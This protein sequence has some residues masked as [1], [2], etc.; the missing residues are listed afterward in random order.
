MKNTD[1]VLKVNAGQSLTYNVKTDISHPGPLAFYIAKV[2]SGQS[3]ATWEP[4]TAKV[5]T[6][7]YQ[8]HPSISSSG[9]TWPSQGA[10][11]VSVTIPKCLADGEY[12][13]R[14]EHIGL[15]SAS[16]AGGAQ[17]YLSCA[18]LSVSGGSGTWS[19]KNTV[20]FPGAYTATDP[21]IMINIYYPIPTSY[22][23]PGPPAETC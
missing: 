12:L 3:V 16:S 14:V 9:M 20:S 2:P 23:P 13:L 18:Q 6:K 8:D 4:G 5:W 21:G 7:I 22:T 10:K 19:P 15:H 1:G 11:S 17:F